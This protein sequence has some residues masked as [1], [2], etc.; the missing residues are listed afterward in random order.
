M[1]GNDIFGIPVNMS[2]KINSCAKK[3]EFVIGGDFFRIARLSQYR[4]RETVGCR[5]GLGKEYPVYIVSEEWSTLS[6]V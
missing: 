1:D 4:F 2:A 5:I 3:N 6:S